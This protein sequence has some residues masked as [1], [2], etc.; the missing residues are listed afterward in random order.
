MLSS[1]HILAVSVQLV[2]QRCM[3]FFESC[4]S[5]AVSNNERQNKS[6]YM[7]APQGPPKRTQPKYKGRF[8][9]YVQL[10]SAV[11]VGAE[12]GIFEWSTGG[13]NGE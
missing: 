1:N 9:K 12:N 10:V 4:G 13:N 5:D 11:K 7:W 8:K 6:S 2:F 3:L